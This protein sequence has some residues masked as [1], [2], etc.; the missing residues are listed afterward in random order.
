MEVNCPPAYTVLPLTARATTWSFALGFQ[1]VAAPLLESMGCKAASVL[2]AYDRKLSPCIHRTAT[3]HKGIYS[4]TCTWIPGSSRAAAGIQRRKAVSALPAYV[5]KGPAC[6]HPI[7]TDRKRIY[8]GICIGIPGSSRAAAGINGRNLV[9][10]LPAY[11]RKPSPYIHRTATDRKRNY[12]CHLHPDSRRVSVPVVA[13]IAA[14]R[15]LL[16]PPTVVKSP[17]MYTV[18]PLRTT[19]L[20]VPLGFGQLS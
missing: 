6:I 18:F 1:E 8:I 9:S 3:D 17:P 15:V 7:A 4:A 16:C 10:V 14:R 5:R 20:T 2:P 19:A 13:S 11:D 12:K